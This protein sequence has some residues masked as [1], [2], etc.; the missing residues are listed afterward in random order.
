MKHT[1]IYLPCRSAFINATFVSQTNKEKQNI[2]DVS[3]GTKMVVITEN[4]KEKCEMQ[5]RGKRRANKTER[6]RIGCR[7][8]LRTEH[9]KSR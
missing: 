4:E 9:R 3:K 5:K 7:L 2:S 8:V 6:V 1:Y